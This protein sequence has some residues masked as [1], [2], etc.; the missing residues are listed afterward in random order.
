VALEVL[1]KETGEGTSD[2]YFKQA[3]GVHIYEDVINNQL[4]NLGNSLLVVVQTAINLPDIT[5]KF[6]IVTLI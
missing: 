2:A 5:S 4:K 6:H 1:K 3:F